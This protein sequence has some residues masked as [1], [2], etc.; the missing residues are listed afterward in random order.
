MGYWG[1]RAREVC[2]DAILDVDFTCIL[3]TVG[4]FWREGP[5]ADGTFVFFSALGLG[6]RA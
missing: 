6:V 4:A 3:A 1:G 2:R 5:M